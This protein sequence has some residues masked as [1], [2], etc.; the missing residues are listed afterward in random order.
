MDALNPKDEHFFRYGELCLL[1]DVNSGA[2][3][4]LDS[5]AEAAFKIL[6]ET[7]DWAQAKKIL[8]EKYPLEAIADLEQEVSNLQKEE[9]LYAADP[10]AEL[11]TPTGEIN[12]PGASS[13][14]P[15]SLCL[16]LA[17]LCN[18][19]CRY[20]F[21]GG[22]VYGN[23]EALMP[24][25]VG[26]AAV[27]F[28]AQNAGPQP[29]W[30]IDFFGGEPLLNW[31][32]VP[33]LV[34]YTKEKAAA[35][36]KKVSFTLTT[37]GSLLDPTKEDFLNKEGIRVVLS[38]DGR[39]EV[40]DRMRVFPNGEGTFA[41]VLP[42]LQHFGR[43]RP[44]HL[45]WYIRGTYTRHNLD[46]DRDFNYLVELGFKHISLEP[47]IA[48]P[49]ADY[50]L[51]PKDL[52]LLFAAYERLLTTIISWEEKGKELDFFH[53]NFDFLQSPCLPKSLAGCGAGTMY[54]AVSPEGELYPCHQLVGQKNYILG[55]VWQGIIF[56]EKA[57]PFQKAHLYQKK[58]CRECWARFLCSGGCHVQALIRHG[59]LQEPDEFTCALQKKRIECALYLTARHKLKE[60]Q[61]FRG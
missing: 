24:L 15:K 26:Y 36:G 53:F 34:A 8:A 30:E 28:L 42:R 16:H 7:K 23:K 49:E 40:N 29:S 6:S 52:P 35:Q 12:L 5:L 54:F 22:G 37:N 55:D 20:C 38:L 14:S 1:L 4:L 61:K 11:L 46:F 3:H 17:H 41:F 44:P 18:F 31:E 45:W 50:A 51:K 25:E 19:R 47:V 10:G 21:A 56:P 60:N 58:A 48:P 9:L 32:L 13:F 57:L 27:D 39:P 59:N 43:T 33:P 2:V